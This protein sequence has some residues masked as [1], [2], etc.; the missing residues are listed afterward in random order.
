MRLSWP[1]FQ[2]LQPVTPA[3]V[4]G[5]PGR[6][7]LAMLA[8][9]AL[10][11]WGRV[12]WL[13]FSLR[14][15][16]ATE[17][18]WIM[19]SFF[20]IAHG[21]PEVTGLLESWLGPPT[22]L[23]EHMAGADVSAQVFGAL[24]IVH[25]T[26][27]LFAQTAQRKRLAL[28]GFAIACC[29]CVCHFMLHTGFAPTLVGTYG[30]PFEPLRNLLWAHTSPGILLVVSGPSTLPACETNRQNNSII[31]WIM[32]AG[33]LGTARVPLSV[34][35]LG[36]DVGLWA[37]RLGWLAIS[38]GAW[39]RAVYVI[40]VNVSK[41]F[42]PSG[43]RLIMMLVVNLTWTTFPALWFV[44]NAGMISTSSERSLLS[45]SDFAAKMI[46][47]AVLMH[48]AN[49]SADIDYRAKHTTLLDTE[50]ERVGAL[51]TFAKSMGHDMRTPL[52]AL[53]FSLHMCQNATKSLVGAHSTGTQGEAQLRA[54]RTIEEQVKQA[55]AC[56]HML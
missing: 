53:V 15:H 36:G 43:K 56:T 54:V 49:V 47:T 21:L 32:L 55:Q 24:A 26:A 42:A 29:T 1:H 17:G 33:F 51:Q 25:S 52:Q 9:D 3:T 14:T 50:R 40:C 10:V 23:A 38:C 6:F 34:T 22:P 5:W 4:L 19:T 46:A 28:L 2:R 39:L 44:G 7:A 12:V 16:W 48:G 31:V 8:L 35:S 41:Q 27:I 37:W 30:R 45:L 20:V 13:P 11:L 18:L